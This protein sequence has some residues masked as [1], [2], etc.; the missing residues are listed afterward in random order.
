MEIQEEKNKDRNPFL[1]IDLFIYLIRFMIGFIFCLFMAS[2]V[3]FFM[4]LYYMD[5]LGSFWMFTKWDLW[6]LVVS[7][8]IFWLKIYSDNKTLKD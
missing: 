8:I 4:H 3:Y 7:N 5:K 2:P 6:L 1:W